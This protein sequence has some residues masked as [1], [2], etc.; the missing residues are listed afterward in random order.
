MF[1]GSIHL[2]CCAAIIT[3]IS[4]TLSSSQTETPFPLKTNSPFPF[5]PLPDNLYFIFSM[6]SQYKRYKNG[7]EMYRNMPKTKCVFHSLFYRCPYTF[8]IHVGNKGNRK[9]LPVLLYFFCLWNR[10]SRLNTIK[11]ST[12]ALY[13]SRHFIVMAPAREA[14]AQ[15]T[16]PESCAQCELWGNQRNCYSKLHYGSTPQFTAN[17]ATWSMV[18]SLGLRKAQWGT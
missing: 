18:P 17:L 6:I 2:H 3:V 1:C 16:S 5:P 9:R 4:R 7:K 10:L 13:C 15:F 11:M 14:G 8:P 12:R